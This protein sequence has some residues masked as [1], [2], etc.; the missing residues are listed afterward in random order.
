MKS[1]LSLAF[2]FLFLG[3]SIASD[4]PEA[5]VD[6]SGQVLR[7]GVNYYVV[8][9]VHGHGGGFGLNSASNLSLCPLFVVQEQL[10][11]THGLP[12]YFSPV[13]VSVE[14]SVVRESTDVK[15]TFN[16]PTICIQGTLW[17]LV[18][19][20]SIQMFAVGTHEVDG[21]PHP[22]PHPHPGRQTLNSWFKIKKFDDGYKLVFCP[23]VC[24]THPPVCGDLGVVIVNG[25]RRLVL[26][27]DPL[28]VVF[29]RA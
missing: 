27:D 21:N 12:L 5:V 14:Q 3:S 16:A 20:G 18:Y 13:A 28:K 2:T 17:L 4:E 29:R 22:H 26:T 8:P 23:S 25:Y 1:A 15:V 19:D 6:T 7:A 24:D 9:A 10:E 11:G